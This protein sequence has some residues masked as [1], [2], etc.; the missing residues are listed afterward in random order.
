[1]QLMHDTM[2]IPWCVDMFAIAVLTR[3][4]AFPLLCYAEKLAGA[5]FELQRQ[6]VEKAMTQNVCIEFALIVTSIFSEIENSIANRHAQHTRI[7]AKHYEIGIL[8][9]QL[10]NMFFVD[11][12]Y[13]R[14]GCDRTRRWV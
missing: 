12:A 13:R 2:H 14:I 3:I 5:R 10:N 8:S 1:M 7:T 9:I 4:I 6:N 11:I